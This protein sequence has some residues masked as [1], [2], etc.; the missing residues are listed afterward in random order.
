MTAPGFVTLWLATAALLVGLGS[1]LGAEDRGPVSDDP[2][3]RL[4]NALL[5]TTQDEPVGDAP[6]GP[7]LPQGDAGPTRLGAL[8]LL[9]TAAAHPGSVSQAESSSPRGPPG[10]RAIRQ[11]VPA[12]SRPASTTFRSTRPTAGASAVVRPRAVHAS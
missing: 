12:P 6:A 5:G 1:D 10:E 11:V 4:E 9:G 3:T 7:M 2:T 8:T